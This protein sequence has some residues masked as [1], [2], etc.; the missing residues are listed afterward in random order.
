MKKLIP[1]L[2]GNDEITKHTFAQLNNP[3]ESSV[4]VSTLSQ[5][6]RIQGVDLKPILTAKSLH[7]LP[8]VAVQL[9][10]M[11]QFYLEKD[12]FGDLDEAQPY[13]VSMYEPAPLVAGD[14]FHQATDFTPSSYL[15]YQYVLSADDVRLAIDSGLYEDSDIFK[16]RLRS[17][18]LESV[19]RREVP[20]EV[21]KTSAGGFDFTLL[22]DVGTSFN[23][24]ETTQSTG[25]GTVL[26]GAL[27][28]VN[29]EY[30]DDIEKARIEA[31]QRQREIEAQEALRKQRENGFVELDDLATS[32]VPD[33]E[34]FDQIRQ[35]ALSSAGGRVADLLRTMTPEQTTTISDLNDGEGTDKHERVDVDEDAIIRRLKAE[36]E[37]DDSTTLSTESEKSEREIRDRLK[38]H[39]A[40]HP[41]HG[42]E[43]VL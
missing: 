2:N 20:V 34:M 10:L 16:S 14:D 41:D 19:V 23:D 27:K 43:L 8:K 1:V 11:P 6:S 3:L 36:A 22:T 9:K 18:L 42:A 30:Q 5:Y 21:A 25:F 38:A 7:S 39:D 13:S 33:D 24:D 37:S 4:E 17:H 35:L 32:D 29:V 31:R 28:A 15:G 12:E 40:E 26:T